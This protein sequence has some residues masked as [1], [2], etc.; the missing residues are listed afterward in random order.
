MHGV[1]TAAAAILLSGLLAGPAKADLSGTISGWV[2]DERG[3]PQMGA[4]VSILT[5]DGLTARRV[6]TD[7]SGQFTATGL[8]PGAY[9]VKVALGRFMPLTRSG[10][11]VHSGRKTVLDVSMRGLFTSLQLVY[12][13]PGT[14]RDM[15]EDWKWVLR[16]AHATRPALRIAPKRPASRDAARSCAS[17]AAPSPTLPPTP[18]SAA[19]QGVAPGALA[20]QSDLGTSFALATSVF[21]DNNVT[22]S[23]NLGNSATGENPSTAFRT[24]Y[25]RD[26]GLVNPEVS[27]TVRQ[28]QTSAVADRAFFG[29]GQPGDNAPDARDVLAGLRRQRQDRRFDGLR[30]RLP[31]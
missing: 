4:S 27:V 20:N 11:A 10:V 28:L 8:M 25:R 18:S 5:T 12:P 23:G 29:S 19:E 9:A 24:S 13:G 21:G 26:L 17:C 14:I 15:T 22:V 6:F 2:R 7:Y 30:V 31:L 16:T 1:A 3:V